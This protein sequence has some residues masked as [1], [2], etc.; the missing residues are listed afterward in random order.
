MGVSSRGDLEV[1]AKQENRA[2]HYAM[3]TSHN[4]VGDN[5]GNIYIP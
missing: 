2:D 5:D 3:G 4:I 1:Y